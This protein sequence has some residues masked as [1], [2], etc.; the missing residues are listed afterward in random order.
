VVTEAG[1]ES[2]DFEGAVG[3]WRGSGVDCDGGLRREDLEDLE[4]LLSGLLSP[5]TL[6]S[7][8]ARVSP[9]SK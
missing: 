2:S 5:A 4:A 7:I 1:L 3:L 9:P 8:P 6:H